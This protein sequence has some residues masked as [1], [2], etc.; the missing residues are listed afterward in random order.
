MST[1]EVL[2]RLV[3]V[4]R[5][6]A[7][8]LRAGPS[9]DA[10]DLELARPAQKPSQRSFRFFD[11]ELDYPTVPPLDWARDYKSGVS[12][13]PRF[14]SAIDYRDSRQV[15]D[16]KYTWELNRHQFLVPWAL[17]Y[18]ATR[19]EDHAAAVVAVILDWIAANPRYQGVNWISSLEHALRILSWG[20][21]LDLCRDS[22]LAQRA[23][24]LVAK[25]VDQQ[26]HFIRWTLSLH[27][28]AN[29]H[30]TGELTGL[31]AA[32]AY[33]PEARKAARYA[34][35]A[36]RRLCHEATVQNLTDGVNREQAIYYHHY[37]LEYLLTASC[38]FARLGWPAPSA[39]HRLTRR[40]LDFVD[41]MTDDHGM[42]FEIGDRD[43][44]T[45]TGLNHGTTVGVFESLLWSGYVVY[46]DD[47]LGSHAARIAR[48]RGAE[49]A[50]DRRNAYWY[51]AAPP[52]AP[53]R[54]TAVPRRVFPKGGY[55]VSRDGSAS[56]VFKAGPFGYP[57]IA[58]HAHCDQLS[59]GLKLG[60]LEILTD[61]GTYVY[62]TEDR[63]RR[64]FKGTAAHN[65]VRVD[66]LDQAEYA[67]PFLWAS[68]ADAELQVL[69]NEP[70]AFD[71]RGIHHG[72]ER[73]PDPVRQVRSVCYR[74]GLGYRITDSLL[75]VT[76]HLF[77]LF[78]N[79]GPDVRPVSIEGL[80]SGLPTTCAWRLDHEGAALLNLVVVGDMPSGVDLVHG[81]EVTPAGFHSRTYLERVPIHRIRLEVRAPRCEFRTYLLPPSRDFRVADLLSL[82]AWS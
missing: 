61:A 51:P 26:A 22:A 71:V 50:I 77:E 60:G 25:S 19:N 32:A 33:F 13:P 59:V 56:L 39:L 14:Y 69:R 73:L 9:F 64:F 7:R 4:V 28:S 21:A 17:D 48:N 6:Q 57:S 40:M 3:Q 24:P 35:F 29:N 30:L 75:G 58:A 38:L 5:N 63:W 42:P 46:G 82:E 79:L 1:A 8:R 54:G 36:G 43:D 11:I 76:P 37:A 2:Y 62:H 65:T 47:A 15:G 45:V 80:G 55:F 10:H 41:A 74:E 16:S 12:A 18:A 53:L 34:R 31:L 23:R 66:G 52:L 70:A 68:H 27:S 78:W 81:D 72:Y 49:P 67:G 20:I 44:G